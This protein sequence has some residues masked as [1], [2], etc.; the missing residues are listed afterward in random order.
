LLSSGNILFNSFEN[1][2]THST[3]ADDD[4]RDG[5]SNSTI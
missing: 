3:M 1:I 5:S 2:L 4:K